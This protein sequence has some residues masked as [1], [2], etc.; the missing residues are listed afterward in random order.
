MNDI[1][2]ITSDI[3]SDI[4]TYM[5]EA[6]GCPLESGAGEVQGFPLES[7][8]GIYRVEVWECQL[9]SGA[10]IYRDLE[11]IKGM[12]HTN[13]KTFINIIKINKI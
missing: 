6:R 12:E 1:F 4:Y 11:L 13:N 9:A 2:N 7:G 3:L 8:A 5:V 10:N